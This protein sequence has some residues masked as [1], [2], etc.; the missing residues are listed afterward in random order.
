ML[1]KGGC[2]ARRWPGAAPVSER[3]RSAI[4]LDF[5]VMNLQK[6]LEFFNVQVIVANESCPQANMWS[7]YHLISRG[8]KNRS[9]K[10]LR[11]PLGS[12]SWHQWCQCC[13]ESP[14]ILTA[15]EV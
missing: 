2:Q 14:R 12:R 8:W 1:F 9:A 11:P 6:L 4:D 5:L 7:N 13:V 15:I 3:F 10:K